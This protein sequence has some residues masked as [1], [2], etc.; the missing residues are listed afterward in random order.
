[1]R[2][3]S[4]KGI[5]RIPKGEM[6]VIELIERVKKERVSKE[7]K[8]LAVVDIAFER[9]FDIPKGDNKRKMAEIERIEREFSE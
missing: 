3:V 1:M 2:I 5:K 6:S 4:R 7:K 8:L 9:I